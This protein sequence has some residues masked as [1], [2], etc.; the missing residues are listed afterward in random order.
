LSAAAGPQRILAIDLGD[1]RSGVAAT[2]WTGTIVVPL[3]A[4]TCRGDVERVAAIEALVR[5]RETELVVV[6]MPLSQDGS[7]GRRA[8]RTR[9]FV[10]ML[11]ARLRVPV[12][13]IDESH[14]THEAHA[15]LEAMGVKAAQRKKIAD[16]VAALV[17][18]ERWRQSD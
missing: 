3:E 12:E 6:G 18:L 16:S 15:R 5:E 17:I 11:R 14:T 10:D 7:E 8:R 9:S 4:I 1:R 13:T 2:D